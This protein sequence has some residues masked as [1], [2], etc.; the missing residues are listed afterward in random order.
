[1]FDKK[2]TP[3]C[4]KMKVIAS[5]NVKEMMLAIGK[6]IVNTNLHFTIL[7]LTFDKHFRVPWKNGLWL[8]QWHGHLG[9]WGKLSSLQ[10]ELA[11]QN[12]NGHQFEI[13]W[14]NWGIWSHHEW[15]NESCC[16]KVWKQTCLYSKILEHDL[17][18]YL[19]LH[20]QFHDYGEF[21]KNT[22]VF[23]PNCNYNVN[24]FTENNGWRIE[25][26]CWHSS[27]RKMLLK[28]LFSSRGL[29][30]NMNL[31]NMFN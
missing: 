9:N 20:G 27:P 24:F 31:Q 29:F 2:Y 23:I 22:K 18:H 14:R 8:C 11:R 12:S 30:E 26:A 1:M 10:M 16:H 21:V 5:E 25:S 6:L 3:L 13:G 19:H 7:V 28:S 4:G 15:E 17:H